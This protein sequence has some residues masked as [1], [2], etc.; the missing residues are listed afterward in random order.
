MPKFGISSDE[1]DKLI[2]FFDWISKVDTNDWPPKPILATAAGVAG[3]E[4]TPG[5]RVYQAQGCDDC[6]TPK[7][8][9]KKTGK[10]YTSHFA[11]TPKV[12]LKDTCLKCHNK[13][14]EEQAIY[15]IDSVKAH[16]KGKIRKAEF[17]PSSLI[18]KIVEAKKAGVDT[19]AIKKAQ[20]Q[21]LKAHIL[22]ELWTAENSDGF[23]NPEMAR[24]SLTRSVNEST[25]GIKILSDTME[26][27]AA[28]K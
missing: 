2:A 3:R 16:I 4:L 28:A 27:K 24:E 12:Q 21:H 10:V 22:W 1:A 6:H 26:A 13:W 11:V 8:K 5:Q 20:E 19:E 15:A 9:D 7:L 17:W 25:K 18:D 14:T 23:H